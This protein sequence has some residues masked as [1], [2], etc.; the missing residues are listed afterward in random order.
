MGLICCSGIDSDIAGGHGPQK[1]QRQGAMA[2]DLSHLPQAQPGL[3]CCD[4]GGAAE[5]MAAG[6][7]WAARFSAI[8]QP[9]GK[10]PALAF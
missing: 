3:V 5:T 2:A 9:R 10:S 1:L 6:F 7:P 4:D 8:S